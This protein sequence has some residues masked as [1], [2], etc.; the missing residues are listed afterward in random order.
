MP[1]ALVEAGIFDQLGEQP[2]AVRTG[3][4]AD[5]PDKISPRI[6]IAE[7]TGDSL[8]VKPVE[9]GGGLV[10]SLAAPKLDGKLGALVAAVWISEACEGRFQNRR[11]PFRGES[12]NSEP[13]AFSE[14]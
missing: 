6:P 10:Q 9:Q 7:G 2:L 1:I 8:R 4:L 13:I 3:R 12:P 14:T 5:F 11:A